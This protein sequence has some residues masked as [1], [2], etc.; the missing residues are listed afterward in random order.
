MK[1]LL[2]RDQYN[3]ATLPLKHALNRL[4]QAARAKPSLEIV[5]EPGAVFRDDGK[6]VVRNP[7]YD[8]LLNPGT[9]QQISSY[10]NQCVQTYTSAR[11]GDWAEQM[12]DHIRSTY[13]RAT[14]T[15]DA[16]RM[17]DTWLRKAIDHG[18]PVYDAQIRE[19]L[20]SFIL[21]MRT[22]GYA[23][24]DT[25]GTQMGEFRGEWR[26]GGFGTV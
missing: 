10:T 5:A 6:V 3:R 14:P 2:N 8:P 19:L 9:Q 18:Y 1:S 16:I 22:D 4:N 15:D 7:R 13:S 26:G 23:D 24:E 12:Q 25:T 20:C 11:A 17:V 21:H